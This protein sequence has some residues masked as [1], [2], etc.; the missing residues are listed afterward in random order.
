MRP[1]NSRA[2]TAPVIF[3]LIVSFLCE[4]ELGCAKPAEH[5][6]GAPAASAL[7]HQLSQVAGTVVLESLY[8]AFT[9][10]HGARRLGYGQPNH[11]TE[12]N[13]FFLRRRQPGNSFPQSQQSQVALRDARGISP[14]A[15]TGSA[16]GTKCNRFARR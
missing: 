8:G 2:T 9:L 14:D 1:P 13:S 4:S 10:A 7:L 15:A 11:E 5:N 6:C 12:S 16:R 3:L